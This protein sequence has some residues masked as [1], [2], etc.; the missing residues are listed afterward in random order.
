MSSRVGPGPVVRLLS[1][2]IVSAALILTVTAL[3]R[4][5]PAAGAQ[6]TQQVPVDSVPPPAGAS[7]DPHAPETLTILQPWERK[8]FSSG[9]RA[10][11][12]PPASRSRASQLD[13]DTAG[14][15]F[16]LQPGDPLI[17][18]RYWMDGWN[19]VFGYDAITDSHILI[20]VTH[21]T[22]DIIAT[23]GTMAGACEGCGPTDYQVELAPG[24][25]TPGVTVTVNFAEAGIE[26][27]EVVEITGDPDIAN[28]RVVGTAPAGGT[29]DAYVERPG[30]RADIPGDVTV[31]ASG[32]YT[33]DFGAQSWSIQPGDT[34]H[35]YYHAPGDHL[36]ESIFWLPVPELGINKWQMGGF[37]RPGGK[38]V[39]GLVYWNNGNGVATDTLIVDTLPPSTSW[40]G[41]TSGTTP[42]IGAGG[43]ITWH[44]GDLQGWGNWDVF[45]VTLDV[46]SSVLTG[47]QV[48]T[49]NCAVITTTAGD[50]DP[51]NNTSCSGPVDVWE[52]DV[53]INVDKWPS[54]WDPAPGQE[55]DYTIR[56]CTDYGANFGP[57][58]LTDTLPVSTT[59]V[60]WNTSEW[61]QALWTEVVT[62]GGQFA[63]YAPGLPGDWCQH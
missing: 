39:Y 25:L 52:S 19:D 24:T 57:V 1:C 63:L 40:A 35:V 38:L 36:V 12:P 28:D 53:G 18:A 22:S 49:G 44:V 21:P 51:N 5:G 7:D 55:F 2:L 13:F 41:D 6:P 34:F 4:A 58:W 17:V 26:V 50:I 10:L 3:L 9:G 27:V 8:P 31:D 30:D 42:D 62:T 54:P 11:Q 45:A 20:T 43:V 23:A 59:V 14:S 48:I 56:W 47:S 46:D 32:V 60:G 61:P 33:L 29:L 37:A 15:Y 16:P